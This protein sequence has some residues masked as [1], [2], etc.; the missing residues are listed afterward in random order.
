MFII[1]RAVISLFQKLTHITEN[2]FFTLYKKM[3]YATLF[4]C[5][6]NCKVNLKNL[7]YYFKIV[8]MHDLIHKTT[9]NSF[10]FLYFKYKRLCVYNYWFWVLHFYFAFCY[11][12]SCSLW[13]ILNWNQ[14]LQYTWQKK[15]NFFNWHSFSKFCFWKRLRW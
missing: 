5:I 3:K 10:V 13:T 15:I 12:I 14:N 4:Q 2:Q 8:R 9:E 1:V 6:K 11:V 7:H